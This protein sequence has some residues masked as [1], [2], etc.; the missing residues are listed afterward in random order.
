MKDVHPRFRKLAGVGPVAP[1]LLHQ[2]R[3]STAE[4]A[5]FVVSRERDETECLG[6]RGIRGAAETK[7]D[8]VEGREKSLWAR[9]CK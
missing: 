4:R 2:S 1:V 7:A 8:P 9:K 3:L 5:E 6:K